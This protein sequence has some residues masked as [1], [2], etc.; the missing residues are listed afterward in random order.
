MDD[1]LR[2]FL[3]AHAPSG[4]RAPVVHGSSTSVGVRGE[5]LSNAEDGQ[6]EREEE[7]R[8][9][10]ATTVTPVSLTF[11]QALW[12][13]VLQMDN[14]M[15]QQRL[16]MAES[17]SYQVDGLRSLLSDIR[18]QGAKLQEALAVN[19]KPPS[20]SAMS[21]TPLRRQLSGGSKKPGKIPEQSMP[22]GGS[23]YE[24]LDTEPPEEKLKVWRSRL[25]FFGVLMEEVKQAM[26]EMELSL[27]EEENQMQHE[28]A[29]VVSS[30]LAMD[31]ERDDNGST[32]LALGPGDPLSYA[33]PAPSVDNSMAIVPVGTA[34][35]IASPEEESIRLNYAR[36]LRALEERLNLELLR[37]KDQI[38]EHPSGLWNEDSHFR[39]KKI[40]REYIIHG[41][42]RES[43]ME[44]LS[45][46]FPHLERKELELRD[47][48]V[49]RQRWVKA[50]R[51]ALLSDYEREKS[52]LRLKAESA[53]G[54]LQRETEERQKV[55]AAMLKQELHCQQVHGELA[56]LKEEF[57][58]KQREK[59]IQERIQEE[60]FAAKE[61]E[62]QLQE[63]LE[64][65][66]KKEATND[67]KQIKREQEEIFKKQMEAEAL[68]Q[69]S[70]LKETINR[71]K[72]RVEQR[73]DE[74]LGIIAYRKQKQQEVM[75]LH[76]EREERLAMAAEKFK[77]EAEADPT[78]LTRLTATL[79]AKHAQGYDVGGGIPLYKVHGFTQDQLM[80]DMR[81]K[82]MSALQTAGLANTE[83]GREL[84]AKTQSIR[85]PR[86]DQRHSAF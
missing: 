55:E 10:L 66:R 59:R 56:V 86:P 24:L 26:Q 74:M 25:Q 72:V 12:E 9:V 22:V 57:D 50:K 28:L 16:D 61:K 46:E 41:K 71:N 49:E 3:A 40:H 45:L 31:N 52:E 39:F 5:P 84:I 1:E 85:P 83:Y 14:D 30:I 79:A 2:S 54:E 29:G 75:Q 63:A 8:L 78:R 4:P 13:E 23:C 68:A 48:F 65:A 47:H 62:R 15:T 20:A 19:T 35:P 33:L 44:R 43:Y 38:T 73:Q 17:V 70:I 42:S 76:Q 36:G 6:R 11:S 51:T 80:K 53:W 18:L 69:Q 32:V 58:R 27:K 7:R 81:F 37:L 21:K 82:V 77:V 64:R 60:R 34:V 67:F